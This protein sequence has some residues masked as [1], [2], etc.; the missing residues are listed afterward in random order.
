MILLQR[1]TQKTKGTHKVCLELVLNGLFL[2]EDKRATTNVQN[3]LVFVLFS[4]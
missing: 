3:G 2:E 4:L 1:V